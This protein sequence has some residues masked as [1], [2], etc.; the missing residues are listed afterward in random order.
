MKP[1]DYILIL[2]VAAALYF[3]FRLA[4]KPRSCCEAGHCEGCGGKCGRKP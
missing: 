3:A 2:A 1:I 4:R